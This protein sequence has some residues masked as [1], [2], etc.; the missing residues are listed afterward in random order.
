MKIYLP[1]TT[2]DAGLERIGRLF[3]EFDRVTIN[4]SG[5]KDSTV[6]LNLALMVAEQK[7]KLPVDVMFLDQE[8]EWDAVKKNWTR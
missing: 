7:G 4:M 8:A 1:Q 5:G 2:L 6:I 3:D